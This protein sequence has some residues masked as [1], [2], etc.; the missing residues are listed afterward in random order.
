MTPDDHLVQKINQQLAAISVLKDRIKFYMD[1]IE[2]FLPR[3]R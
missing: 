1:E 2:M 3:K